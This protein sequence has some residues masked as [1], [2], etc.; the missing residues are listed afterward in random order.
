M[1]GNIEIEENIENTASVSNWGITGS[2]PYICS[3]EKRDSGRRD[4][5]RVANDDVSQGLWRP[6]EGTKEEAAMEWTCCPIEF[7]KKNQNLWNLCWTE[8]HERRKEAQERRRRRNDLQVTQVAE[9]HDLSHKKLLDE[10]ALLQK[11]K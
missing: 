4:M 7:H 5:V 9:S 2:Q 6:L 1:E 8:P 10:L 11:K 3:F